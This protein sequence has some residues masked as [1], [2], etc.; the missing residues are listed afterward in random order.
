MCNC[1]ADYKICL[2]DFS[3]V[4]IDVL[5]KR[6]KKPL[7]L[8]VHST[9]WYYVDFC[10]FMSCLKIIFTPE[11]LSKEYSRIIASNTKGPQLQSVLHEL[12]SRG[13]D[14]KGLSFAVRHV[15]L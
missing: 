3:V 5:T 13:I 2:G 14:A 7:L 10:P 11:E 12:H 1:F 8:E 6:S 15:A 9:G 4:G